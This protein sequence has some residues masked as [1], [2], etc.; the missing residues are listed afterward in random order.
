MTNKHIVKSYDENLD[1]LRSKLSEMGK[2]VEDQ[3]AKA[4]QALLNPSDGLADIVIV[5]DEK[6]NFLQRE[7]EELGVRI[8]ATRQ[9]VAQ[10]LRIVIAGFK[11]ASELER[12]ADYAANIAKHIPDLDDNLD[13]D[14]PIATITEMAEL[15]KEM[16]ADIMDAFTEC[17]V[18]KAITVWHNDDQIDN[19]YAELLGELGSRMSQDPDNVKSYTALIFIARCCERIGDHITNLA[20]NVHYIKHGKT[21][22]DGKVPLTQKQ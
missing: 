7:V 2:E 19:L 11:M 20:E 14:K 17:D 10:D 15:G 21:Y 12:T 6:V 3:I 16:L 5:S 22:I 1:L 13:L 9:P 18:Q 8:L 4:K